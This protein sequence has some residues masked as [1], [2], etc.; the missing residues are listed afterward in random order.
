MTAPKEPTFRIRI[1]YTGGRSVIE[2]GWTRG[3][4]ERLRTSWAEIHG[5]RGE[6]S[7]ATVKILNREKGR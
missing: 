4:I 2:T 5:D 6:R 1:T 3:M 7:Q